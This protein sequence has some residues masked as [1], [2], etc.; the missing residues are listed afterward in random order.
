MR[1]DLQADTEAFLQYPRAFSQRVDENGKFTFNS[2]EPGHYRIVAR[3]PD[4]YL[5]VKAITAYAATPARRGAARGANPVGGVSQNGFTLRQGEKMTIGAVT[6]AEGAAVLR[7]KVAPENEGALLPS[8]LR[9]HLVPVDPK[10]AED[11]LRYSETIVRSEGAF[12]FNNIAPGKYR[13]LT[14]VVPDDEPIDRPPLPA[15]WD[16]NERANLRKEAVA[17]NVEVELK[18]CQRLT[19]QVVKYR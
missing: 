5:Y 1:D 6:F 3:S 17:M 18:P 19:D 12:A 11:V 4:E 2:V 16:A 15:A 13:L 7:G 8:R 10:A 9:L 14:R